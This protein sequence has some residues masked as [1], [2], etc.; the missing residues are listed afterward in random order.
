[1]EKTKP[2]QFVKRYRDQGA[3]ID[4]IGGELLL[5][6]SE[7]DGASAFLVAVLR[8]NDH[9][10]MRSCAYLAGVVCAYSLRVERLEQQLKEHNGVTH[11]KET[12]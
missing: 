10:A 8:A 6:E 2:S 12:R 3:A 11:G 7:S 5:S 4:A 1:M 9:D